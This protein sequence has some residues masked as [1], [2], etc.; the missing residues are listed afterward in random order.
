MG[1][2]VRGSSTMFNLKTKNIAVRTF[3]PQTSLL[4]VI[5]PDYT[6]TYLICNIERDIDYTLI[7][8]T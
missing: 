5:L 6:E 8:I 4:G 7:G 1:R 3:V 2:G